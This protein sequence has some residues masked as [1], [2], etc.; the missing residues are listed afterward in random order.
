MNSSG[1]HGPELR[2]VPAHLA[3]TPVSVVRIDRHA[4]LV[5][6]VQFAT[7]D[8]AAQCRFQQQAAARLRLRQRREERAAARLDR[9][10]RGRVRI[11]HEL[12]GVDVRLRRWQRRR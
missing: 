3:S 1:S 2:I 6:V 10:T 11:D 7:L 5:D 9:E 4:R 8:R 12:L